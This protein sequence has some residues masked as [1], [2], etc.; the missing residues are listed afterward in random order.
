[1]QMCHWLTAGIRERICR[2]WRERKYAGSGEREAMQ[3]VER[4]GLANFSE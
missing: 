3:G 2:E 4:V 1:M